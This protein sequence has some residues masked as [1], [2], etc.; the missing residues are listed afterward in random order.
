LSAAEA[1]GA[2][3]VAAGLASVLN[4][5]KNANAAGAARGA[6]GV[7]QL[8]SARRN[9]IARAQKTYAETRRDKP[10]RT[11]TRRKTRSGFGGTAGSNSSVRDREKM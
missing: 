5:R 9:A 1:S 4:V 2:V 10:L 7:A 8:R 6:S 3:A 11:R